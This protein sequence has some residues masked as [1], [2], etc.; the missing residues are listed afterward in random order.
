MLA[1]LKLGRT[2]RHSDQVASLSSNLQAVHMKKG[3]WSRE[4]DAK[5]EQCMRDCPKDEN[6]NTWDEIAQIAG[7]ERCGKSCRLRWTNYLRPDIKRG[8]FSEEE[9]EQIIYLHSLFGN[10]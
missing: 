9:E 5:L 8:K 4:E 2:V 7:L 10:R 6:R 3:R 1:E